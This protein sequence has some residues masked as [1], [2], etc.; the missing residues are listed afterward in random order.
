MLS[1][2]G[3]LRSLTPLLVLLGS[4]GALFVVQLGLA[5]VSTQIWTLPAYAVVI[6][7]ALG[8]APKIQSSEARLPLFAAHL[9]GLFLAF[10]VSSDMSRVSETVS[11]MLH[12]AV[13]WL[14]VCLALSL[15]L[16]LMR[17][18]R[19]G[20]S[21]LAWSLGVCAVGCVVAFF[22]GERGGNG[23]WID[24]A[25]RLFGWD[26]ATAET[27]VMWLRKSMHF[28]FYGA[29]AWLGWRTVRVGGGSVA[30]GL[31]AGAIVALASAM[32]DEGRQL[33]ATNRGGNGW[34]V[35]LDMAG[36]ATVLALAAVRARR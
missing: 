10:V 12:F 1:V 7:A 31:G 6:A 21:P 30:A 11:K 27:A 32:L 4:F 28:G 13:V 17:V 15:F 23:S 33:T 5:S 29:V 16:V 24:E 25:M 3:W 22:S 20:G 26:R 18:L 34:D 19:K 2:R 14:W 9:C 8:L 35:V 36:A